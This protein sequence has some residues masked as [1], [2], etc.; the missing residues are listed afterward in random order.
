MAPGVAK[1]FIV[2]LHL[3]T[4]SWDAQIADVSQLSELR[5]RANWV[6]LVVCS[7]GRKCSFRKRKERCRNAC[8]KT[9]A[10]RGLLQN[11]SRQHVVHFKNACVEKMPLNMCIQ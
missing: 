5:G 9:L 4:D 8:C 11:I 1:I 2:A 7:N 6:G 10:C 3:A